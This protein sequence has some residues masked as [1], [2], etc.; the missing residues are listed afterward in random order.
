MDSVNFI[1]DGNAPHPEVT[2][3]Y[4]GFT[5]EEDVEYEVVYDDSSD[6]GT[7]YVT[8]NGIGE[9]TG[10]AKAEYTIEKQ[11]Q[12]VKGT[13]SYT[14]YVGDGVFALDAQ[15]DGDGKLVYGSSNTAVATVTS[16]GKVTVKGVGTAQ[17]S[18]YAK[19]TEFSAKSAIFK[20][21]VKVAKKTQKVTGTASYTKRVGDAAFKLNAATNGNGALVYSSS[22]TK[23]AVVSSAGKVSIKGVGTA[24]ISI[25]AKDTEQYNKSNVLKVTIK[26]TK[27]PQTVT[28]TATYNKVVGQ[29][30]FTVKASTNGNGK[31]YYSTTNKAVAVV[32]K[33]GKVTIKGI[34]IAKIKVYAAETSTYSKSATKVITI[35]VGPKKMALSSVANTANNTITAKWAKQAGVSGYQIQYSAKSDFSKAKSVTAGASAV[36]K[37]IS[38]LT[39]NATYYVRIR[40]FKTVGSA[41]VYSPWSAAKSVKISKGTAKTFAKTPVINVKGHDNELKNTISWAKLSGATGY[42]VYAKK[43][44]NGTWTKVKVTTSLQ[45]VHKVTH[46]VWYYYKVRAYQDLADGSRIYGKYSGEKEMLQYYKPNF[47]VFTS[48]KSNSST[49]MFL[50]M[51]TNNG[52]GTLRIYSKGA[53]SSDNDYSS[54]NRQLYLADVTEDHMN[55]Y[56][57]LSYMDIKPGETKIVTFMSKEGKTWYDSKTRVYYEFRYDGVNYYGVTSNYYGSS[58]W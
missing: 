45:Y 34:G 38:G 44:T 12:V 39:K 25:Y 3:S 16:D 46:G 11:Q 7:H 15:T 19:E 9:Y 27:K 30:A 48:S 8:I 31:L 40:S 41:K 56:D 17:I 58:Y 43:G 52:V 10:T 36:S 53:H 49:D 47:S 2:V 1:Y 4:D 51:I 28:V 23:A 14:K 32:D 13:A 50:L 54:Y 33:A 21:T 6:L 26:V 20:V 37:A 35:N 18:I 42:E 22:N 55:F 57:E 24:V 29:P 5:L